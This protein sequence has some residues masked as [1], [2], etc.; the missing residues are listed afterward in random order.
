MT[1]LLLD[2]F[3]GSAGPL[4]AHT[5]D[6][7]VTWAAFD[8]DTMENIA[9][10][11]SGEVGLISGA[12]N[13]AAS[14]VTP[15]GDYSLVTYATASTT[16][17]GSVT[18][19]LQAINNNTDFFGWM[20]EIGASTTDGHAWLYIYDESAVGA[21]NGVAITLDVEH[22]YQL[23]V[24]VSRTHYELYVD[25]VLVVTLDS[26]GAV[27]ASPIGLG[28][29]TAIGDPPI[30]LNSIE[31]ADTI[32]GGPEPEPEPVQ[33]PTGPNKLTKDLSITTIAGSPG[34]PGSP[35]TAPRPAYCVT[36]ASTITTYPVTY[37]YDDY[38]VPTM[39][40]GNSATSTVN[41][42][43]CYPA[44]PGTP[45]VPAVPGTADTTI[46]QFNLGWNGGARSIANLAADGTAAFSINQSTVGAVVGLDSGAVEFSYAGAEHALYFH[47]GLVS[48]LES[49]T[50]R[51]GANSY[52][53]ADVFRIERSSSVVRYYQNDTLLYTSTNPSYGTQYLEASLY[54]GGDAVL[55]ASLDDTVT[56]GA[57]GTGDAPVYVD[58]LP[59]VAGGT[60]LMPLDA[61]GSGTLDGDTVR[62]YSS[63]TAY[64]LPMGS[65]G[66][67]VAE[68]GGVAVLT[69][70]AALGADR[71]YGTGLAA[72]SPLD[73][74]AESGTAPTFALAAAQLGYIGSAGYGLTSG[75]TTG[76]A[77][78]SSMLPLIGLGSNYAY[79]GGAAAFLPLSSFGAP[80]IPLSGWAFLTSPSARLDAYGHDSTGEQSAVLTAPSPITTGFGGATARA[81]APRPSLA[82]TA[83][84]TSFGAA[85]LS[86][87]VGLVA[88]SGTTTALAGANLKAPTGRAVGYSGAVVS[89]TLAG[90][91]TV[92][93]SGTADGTGTAQIT[94]PLFELTAS[95][96]MQNFGGANLL[97]P[98]PE[99]A[100]TAQAW[101]IAPGAQ[102]TA[103][104]TAVIAV[105]YEA[106][107]IN[108]NHPPPKPGVPTID[109][110][111]HYT[112]FPFTH[113][114]R[115]QNSYFGVNS[116]GLYL[117]EGTTD[118]AVPTSFAVKTATSDLGSQEKKTVAS[119]Y[120]G[121]RFGPASTIG[122]QAGEGTPT[123]YNFSTPRDAL[124]QNHRQVFGKG[125]K[126]K[127]Y[128]LSV[129]GTGVCE[130]D[131]IELDVHKLTRRL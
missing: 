61:F 48:V 5:G 74:S 13:V 112:S 99:L 97:A 67:G 106:Y 121:G 37:I 68:Q 1:T 123:L 12:F 102:L 126:E 3:T 43:T 54:S 98:S 89:I 42:T 116:T 93:A 45:P 84:V 22:K 104:G 75:N 73:S 49:G 105:A 94:C 91:S 24:T 31:V 44:T 125:L 26:P 10:T 19:Y 88:A 2:N 65:E 92:L 41:T 70:L 46:T 35:G 7:G 23:N 36:T 40:I 15:A 28:G 9:L 59:V 82:I 83:T 131:S 114:V 62:D 53:T 100:R 87:P 118:D 115:Y 29:Y 32:G 79:G 77:A 111:T 58:G 18:L 66:T 127:H 96:T 117:L 110:V 8:T 95:A 101:L 39:L 129:S 124:A 64:L 4:D 80:L 76:D 113:V 108:L 16:T 130:L 21:D 63:A 50:L 11:G 14:S 128:A 27:P 20:L 78:A 103:I 72:L 38:G 86:A 25:D 52:L 34:S 55:D 47:N 56:A 107:A 6:S 109:E 85:A 81:S 57:G 69:P 119:A 51:T 17:V 120:F 71:S 90:K 122:L 33:E 60:A 30:T